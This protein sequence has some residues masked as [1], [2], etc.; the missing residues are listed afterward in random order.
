MVENVVGVYALPL[1]VG[2]NFRVNGS[3]YLVPMAS[4]SRR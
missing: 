2:L 1:G 3:D 4:R